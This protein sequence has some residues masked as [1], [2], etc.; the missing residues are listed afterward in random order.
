MSPLVKAGINIEVDYKAIHKPTALAKFNVHKRLNRDVVLLRIFPSIR[1]ET[2]AHFMKPPIQGVVLQC[3]GAGNMPTNRKD[4][5]RLLKDA[6]A[7][8]V[9]IVSVTQCSSGMVSGLYA[10]GKALLDIGVIPGNDMTPEAA[11]TKMS[12]VLSRDEWDIDMKRKMMQTNIAG[13]MTVINFKEEKAKPLKGDIEDLNLIDAL[14]KTLHVTTTEEMEGLT[15]VLLPSI[16]CSAVFTGDVNRL[17][18]LHSAYGDMIDFSKHDYDNRTPLHVAAAEGHI[19]VVEYLLK[20][21]ASVH[22]RDRND[23]TPLMDAIREGHED[24]IKTLIKVGAH[25][26]QGSLELGERLCMLARM[27][28]VSQLSCYHLAGANLST[29]KNMARQTPLHAAVETAQETTVEFLLNHK[30]QT[31]VKDVYGRTPMDVAKLLKF[32]DVHKMLETHLAKTHL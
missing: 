9:I 28:E 17:E 15:V 32:H 11:L 1:T 10:T 19:S 31:D 13:E 8:G 24:V 2:V 4:I 20:Q 7:R 23:N 25:L 5:M 16:L 30:V 18:A 26:H 3:Y 27:G 6:S 12:Y 21:G 29:S 14:A 22:S